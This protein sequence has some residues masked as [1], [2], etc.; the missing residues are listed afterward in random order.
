[1]LWEIW[2]G[3]QMKVDIGANLWS[4]LKWRRF[5]ES[6]AILSKLAHETSLPVR[7]SE[8][9]LTV[10]TLTRVH[11]KDPVAVEVVR[12]WVKEMDESMFQR[13]CV[14]ERFQYLY[15]VQM[16]TW[17]GGSATQEWG[18]KA[19]KNVENWL[20]KIITDAV[21]HV[22]ESTQPLE[23]PQVYAGTAAGALMQ[24]CMVKCLTGV[25]VPPPPEPLQMYARVPNE[26]MV[27]VCLRFWTDAPH[28]YVSHVRW[29]H[30]RHTSGTPT[31]VMVHT[32]ARTPARAL[33]ARMRGAA[34]EAAAVVRPRPQLERPICCIWFN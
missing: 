11:W 14:I 8:D 2:M 13:A 7:G 34:A 32:Y 22:Q 30:R 19:I 10:V 21:I 31:G 18:G 4:G 6:D 5:L 17:W 25:H 27:H 23:P 26:A 16:V 15:A 12:G 9:H 3:T 33:D 20:G 24:V 1:M 28:T 29:N